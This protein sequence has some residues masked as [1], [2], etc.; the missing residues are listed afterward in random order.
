MTSNDTPAGLQ[1][2]N[3]EEDSNRAQGNADDAGSLAASALRHAGNAEGQTN[4]SQW[5]IQPVK[6]ADKRYRGNKP[7]AYTEN[8]QYQS[9]YLHS[10]A[11]S[12]LI[13]GNNG[14]PC[15]PIIR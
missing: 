2:Q 3:T 5:D 10:S 7:D 9:Q 4:S 8:T 15:L 13:S 1:A 11:L 12:C 14:R 6:P